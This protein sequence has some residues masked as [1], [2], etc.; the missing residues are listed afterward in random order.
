MSNFLFNDVFPSLKIVFILANNADHDEMP[1]YS[2]FH[3]GIHCLLKYLFT[4]K[5]TNR[6]PVA[7]CP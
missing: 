3:Q 2:A 4:G 7:Q 6:G 5:R 1:P